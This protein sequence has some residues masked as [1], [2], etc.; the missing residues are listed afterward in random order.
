MILL[1]I[2]AALASCGPTP[3]P[4]DKD[5]AS[6]FQAKRPMFES[7]RK[8]LCA[9]RYD[10]TVM[11]DPQW[12]QPQLPVTEERRYRARLAEIGA[13]GVKYLRGCQLWIEVWSS[14]VGGD[15]AYKK[16][17]YGPPLYRIIEVKPPLKPGDPPDKDLN[18]YLD[19]RVRIA[20][21]QKKLAGDWW[22][23][24]DHWR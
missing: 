14:G 10:Q 7:L 3:P 19:K 15:A 17:R 12:A 21:F 24:L 8:D 13:S 18:T 4:T 20:S 22:I 6:L 16:Y 11:R 2:L 23:E 5:M 9:L 1:P